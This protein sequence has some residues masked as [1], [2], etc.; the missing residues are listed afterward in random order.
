M[1]LNLQNFVSSRLIEKLQLKRAHAHFYQVQAQVL[2]CKATYCDFVIWSE[3][4][5][6][7]QRILPKKQFIE[8]AMQSVTFF[9]LG[10]MAELV[11]KWFSKFLVGSIPVIHARLFFQHNS[12]MDLTLYGMLKERIW[13]Q[14][15]DRAFKY[16]YDCHPHLPSHGGKIMMTMLTI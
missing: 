14:T 6:F 8:E 16:N 15:L 10:I 4:D 1:L 2:V 11:G 7:I 3:S 9:K 5:L 13:F 12:F